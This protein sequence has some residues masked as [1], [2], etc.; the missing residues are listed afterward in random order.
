MNMIA[1]NRPMRSFR[2]SSIRPGYLVRADGKVADM[3]FYVALVAFQVKACHGLPRH[4]LSRPVPE[5]LLPRL[6]RLVAG[7]L[8]DKLG[9]DELWH[10]HPVKLLDGSSVN[11]PD[12]PENQAAYP[13][14]RRS[15]YPYPAPPC[16]ARLHR[17]DSRRPTHLSQPPSH[18]DSRRPVPP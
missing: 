9:P 12:T 16:S 17:L 7:R 13:Q 8:E 11:M 3:G 6:T 14:P 5:A 18:L 1:T 10:G 2:A 15:A 4:H